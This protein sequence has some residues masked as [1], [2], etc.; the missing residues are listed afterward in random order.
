MKAYD[1]H[2][3]PWGDWVLL[4]DYERLVDAARARILELE[5]ELERARINPDALA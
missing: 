5:R 2:T 4:S 3:Q 1:R